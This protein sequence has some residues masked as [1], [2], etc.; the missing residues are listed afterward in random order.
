M[1]IEPALCVNPGTAFSLSPN[2][3]AYGDG[4]VIKSF[5][6]PFKHLRRGRQHQIG[7]D[8]SILSTDAS[9]HPS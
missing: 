2:T 7:T 1:A 8:L 9:H 6:A 3:G 4:I 5:I